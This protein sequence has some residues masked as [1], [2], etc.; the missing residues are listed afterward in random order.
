MS[1]YY[2]RRLHMSV[3]LSA[4]ELK[5]KIRKENRDNAMTVLKVETLEDMQNLVQNN[6][7][8]LGKRHYTILCHYLGYNRSDYA[9]T[10]STIGD[11]VGI[12]TDQAKKNVETALSRLKVKREADMGKDSDKGVAIFEGLKPRVK[13]ALMASNVYS[14]STVLRLM[15]EHGC[16]N[17]LQLNDIMQ[18]RGIGQT[19]CGY[20][21]DV[22]LSNYDMSNA[23]RTTKEDKVKFYMN[24]IKH[25]SSVLDIPEEYAL[26]VADAMSYKLRAFNGTDYFVMDSYL[27]IGSDHTDF[28]NPENNA[29]YASTFVEISRVRN[30]GL[31]YVVESYNA[32]LITIKTHID[33][34][35]DERLFRFTSNDAIIMAL[36]KGIMSFRLYMKLV[37]YFGNGSMISFDAIWYKIGLKY[38]LTNEII[39]Q[40]NLDD[41]LEKELREFI[42]RYITK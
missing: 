26:Y 27:G 6:R 3:E 4:E 19:M 21:D 7:D 10:M 17:S 23:F 20:L 30:I 16:T 38:D 12:S 14:M 32:S 15:R 37:R 22:I 8:F 39:K 2:F 35:R 1:K 29:E 36:I 25:L 42:K 33:S 34:F 13:K 41:E 11:M 9:Y 24:R 40:T 31:E 28:L 18:F 5:E